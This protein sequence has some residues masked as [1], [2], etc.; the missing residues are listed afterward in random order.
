MDLVDAHIIIIIS[1]LKFVK[2]K[3]TLKLKARWGL[4]YSLKDLYLSIPDN[5]VLFIKR[6]N[7]K[8]DFPLKFTLGGR[9]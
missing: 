3:Y 5:P 9:S 6:L 7:F 4:I 8:K 1:I 2:S